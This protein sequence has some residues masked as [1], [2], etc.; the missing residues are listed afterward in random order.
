[1]LGAFRKLQVAE[2]GAGEAD[3]GWVM[4]SLSQYQAEEERGFLLRIV[5]E[6]FISSKGMISSSRRPCSPPRIGGN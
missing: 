3:R 5:R 6:S 2:D 4:F 1:M